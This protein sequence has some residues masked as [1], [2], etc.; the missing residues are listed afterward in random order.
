MRTFVPIVLL[1]A[2]LCCLSGA[3]NAQTT[4]M[5]VTPW[6]LPFDSVMVGSVKTDSVVVKNVGASDLTLAVS[7]MADST[8][9]VTPTGTTV[10]VG[11]SVTLYVTFAPMDPGPFD[12][13]LVLNTNTLK[14][15]DTVGGQEV[16]SLA[17][18]MMS[19]GRY[20]Y[21]F[22]ARNLSSGLY[23]YRLSAGEY[24][25]VMKMMLVK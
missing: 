25:M 20:T 7:P 24:H 22:D 15:Q 5:E 8:F 2:T 3:A 10:A 17:T 4:S 23:F 14:V 19:A 12:A 18:G 21:T 13:N 9:V 1:L 16:A 6:Y 11:D